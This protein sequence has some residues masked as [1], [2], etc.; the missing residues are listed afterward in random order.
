MIEL[1]KIQNLKVVR[2]TEIGVYL[3]SEASNGEADILLPKSQV[4]PE[5]EIGDI[6]EVFVYKD[7]EDRMI[8]TVKNPKVTLGNLAVLSVVQ[9]TR[10]GAFLDWGLEKDLFLPFKQQVGEVVRGKSYLVGIYIDK[11]DRLCATMKVYDLLSCESP[12]SENSKAQG[13]IYRITE[14]YG[15]FVAVDNKYH[16]LIPHKEIY[17]SYN[18]GDTVDVRVKKIRPDGKLE[19][20]LRKQAFYQME[21]D[22]QKIMNKLK[23]NGGSLHLSDKS[24]PESIKTELNMSKASFKRAVGRL[25]KEGAIKI[26]DDGIQITWEMD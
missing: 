19:L 23:L 12:Y 8:A 17:G 2:K 1:G 9:I 3:N 21:D 18:I 5:T 4:P 20:S 10:I 16:G 14:E 25:L 7:S 11:S 24:S 6:I 15:A 26:T 22:A 13:I